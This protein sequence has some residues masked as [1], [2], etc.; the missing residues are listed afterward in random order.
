MLSWGVSP[1]RSD[2]LSRCQGLERKVDLTA[3]RFPCD[4]APNG[5]I[6]SNSQQVRGLVIQAHGLK[7]GDKSS[8]GST[9]N[10][11]GL[12]PNGAGQRS[13]QRVHQQV[14]DANRIARDQSSTE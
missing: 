5:G 8:R 12:I 3:I 2:V 10:G 14:A 4:R 13:C 11:V 1:F 9:S 6:S 7:R